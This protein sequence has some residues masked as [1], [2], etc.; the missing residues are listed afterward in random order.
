MKPLTA[1]FGTDDSA[2]WE[3]DR[4]KFSPDKQKVTG[5]KST[6]FLFILLI[7]PFCHHLSFIVTSVYFIP[8]FWFRFLFLCHYSVSI[9][10]TEVDSKLQIFRGISG[11]I[12]QVYT[13]LM[14]LVRRSGDDNPPPH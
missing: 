14:R 13:E 8:Y 4:D 7:P 12:A 6:V 1:P 10:K 3:K 5:P 2:S 11:A 9:V